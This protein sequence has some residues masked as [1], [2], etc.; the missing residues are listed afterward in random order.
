MRYI[1]LIVAGLLIAAAPASAQYAMSRPRGAVPLLDGCD[2]MS[3][4]PDCHPD[5]I[6]E[7]RSVIPVHPNTPG[8]V[9]ID[10]A[11]TPYY[12]PYGR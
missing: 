4:Y 2:G 3:G 7:G 12:P 9:L 10:P 6:Y 8:V 5:R 1:A 11:G